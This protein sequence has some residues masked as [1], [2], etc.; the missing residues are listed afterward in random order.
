MKCISTVGPGG[1][2]PSPVEGGD[3]SCRS[4]GGGNSTRASTP[5]PL[6]HSFAPRWHLAP[7]LQF[8]ST[9]TSAGEGLVIVDYSTTWCGPCKVMEPKFVA[10]SDENPS[11]VFVKVTGDA[12]PEASKL[13]KREGVRSVPSFHFWKNG[14][15]VDMVNGANVD[16]VKAALNKWQ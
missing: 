2:S 12:S 10:M 8:D 11:T 14:E 4:S 1:T 6:T 16:A 15:K 7:S 9:I 3:A 5:F 13:M